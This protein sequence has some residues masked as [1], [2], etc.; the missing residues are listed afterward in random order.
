MKFLAG[1]FGFAAICAL[2]VGLYALVSGKHSLDNETE[3]DEWISQKN[4]ESLGTVDDKTYESAF[5][6]DGRAYVERQ[7]LKNA[8]VHLTMKGR[9]VLFGKFVG[10]AVGSLLVGVF[11]AFLGQR[12]GGKT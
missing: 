5:H 11:A 9:L 7:R 1:L 8:V 2:F 3:Y 4:Y 10:Y 12:R 6:D